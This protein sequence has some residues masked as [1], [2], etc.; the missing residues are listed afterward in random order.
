MW[1][2]QWLYPFCDRLTGQS[3]V[4]IRTEKKN[5]HPVC[6][7]PISNLMES[8]DI[9]RISKVV[10]KAWTFPF[11]SRIIYFCTMTKWILSINVGAPESKHNFPELRQQLQKRPLSCLLMISKVLFFC[12]LALIKMTHGAFAQVAKWD[13]PGSNLC[14]NHSPSRFFSLSFQINIPGG[15]REAVTVTGHSPKWF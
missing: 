14:L 2:S 3:Q 13:I 11:P 1:M 8:L 7:W 5:S 6:N 9:G 15:H 4:D 10:L 12:L